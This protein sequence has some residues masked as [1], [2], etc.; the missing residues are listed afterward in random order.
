MSNL[1]HY[2]MPFTAMRGFYQKP[3]F[4]KRSEGMYYYSD[5]DRMVIDGASGLWC[6]NAGH[7]RT[8]IS[9]AIAQQAYEMAYAPP[10][11]IAH[12]LA[13]ELAE[14]L[15]KIAPE[16]MG[17]VFFTNSG[18]ESVD[19]ALKMALAYHRSNGQAS[20]TR[21]IGRE[22]GY[23]GV[24]FG[25]ISVG[26]MVNNRKQFG[27]MLPGVDH[28][29]HTL[30]IQKHAFTK[31]LP[32]GGEEYADVLERLVQL[33]DASTI[34][35]VIVEPMAGSTGVIVPPE[36]YLK[37]LREICTKHGILLIFD[38]VITGFGRVGTPFASTRLEVTPDIMTIAKGLTNG[39]IPMGAVIAKDFIFD[40]IVNNA[41]EGIEFFHGY[42]YSASPIACAA[43]LAALRI[44]ERDNL[45]DK[46]LDLEDYLENKVHELRK[47]KEVL[48]IRN[49]GM[50]AAVELKPSSKGPGARGYHTFL[51]AFFEE[52]LLVRASGDVLAIAPPL[53]AGKA[54]LDL[55]VDRLGAAIEDAVKNA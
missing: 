19:T 40:S 32:P 2:W 34:A 33:H 47:I 44:Y 12:P 10:F 50:V 54:E 38:E 6:V 48:D 9:E 30:N 49:W 14:K 39:A 7:S 53:I 16:G 25:G 1:S 26:G 23:H 3:R 8:E 22:R 42:T 5:D 51:K 45:F 27:T 35:A 24:G 41:P 13:F 11:Q 55:I 28:L 29:P 18:S 4:L 46:A 20:R 15:V 52:N 21:F 17:K 43:A 37:R 31:G 36:N